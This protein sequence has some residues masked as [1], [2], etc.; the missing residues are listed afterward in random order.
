MFLRFKEELE[1]KS[2]SLTLL[3]EYSMNYLGTS[4]CEY[5]MDP[6]MPQKL[7]IICAD[8]NKNAHIF[9]YST[10]CTILLFCN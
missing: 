7:R 1:A 10:P 2:K 3:S 4:S 5:W 9:S 8:S 6:Y